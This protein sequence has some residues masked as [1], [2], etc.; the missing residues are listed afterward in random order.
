MAMAAKAVLA[1]L[2]RSAF[3]ADVDGRDRDPG[4]ILGSLLGLVIGFVIA[5]VASTILLAIYG[6]VAGGSDQLLRKVLDLIQSHTPDF[7]GSIFILLLPALSNGP[8][9]L[10]FIAVAA[11]LTHRRIRDYVSAAHRVRWRLLAAGLLL[12]FALTGVLMAL[13]HLITPS[14]KP[15]P[16]LSVSPQLIERGAYALMAIAL[17]IPAAAAEEVV[18]RGWLLRQTAAFTRS[19]IAILAINGVLFAAAHLDFGPE[20]FLERMTM[21]AGFAYMALRL[22]GIEFATG[23][24]AANNILIVLFME[25]F[26]LAPSAPTGFNAGSVLEDVVLAAG[27]VLIAEAVVRMPALR[28]LAGI[29]PA[30]LSAPEGVAQVF[31]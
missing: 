30:D 21:G 31:S 26:I 13:D 5:L 8:W 28:H 17:L 12:N 29:E 14:A 23:A 24:H 2:G 27:Y 18:F 4:R 3:L 10:I 1:G 20:A 11:A 15:P 6:I 25:P 7:L 19:P 16:I 22:G 9:A